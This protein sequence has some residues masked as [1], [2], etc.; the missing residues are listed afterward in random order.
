MWETRRFFRNKYREIILAQNEQTE[1]M[2]ELELKVLQKIKTMIKKKQLKPGHV[3]G[4]WKAF[5]M[6]VQAN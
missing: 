1:T 5:V 2:E 4:P 3:D 6:R